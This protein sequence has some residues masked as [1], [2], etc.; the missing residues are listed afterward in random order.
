MCA[1]QVMAQVGLSGFVKP[2]LRLGNLS[3]LSIKELINCL[4]NHLGK[5]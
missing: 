5:I 1:N 3:S 4:L 2:P